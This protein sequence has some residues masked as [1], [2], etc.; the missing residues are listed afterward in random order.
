MR[1][2]LTS[3]A[4]LFFTLNVFSQYSIQGRLLDKE[5]DG[6]IEMATISL[7]SAKDS[8]LISGA[9]SDYAGRYSFSKVAKGDYLISYKYLGY[10][11]VIVQL[12][13]EDKSQ[14]LKNVYLEEEVTNLDEVEVRGMAAQMIIKGDTTEYNAAAFKMQE[15]AVVEDLFK[16]LP[17]FMIESDGSIMVNGE[18]IGR[19]RVDGR[20]FFDGDMEMIT[21]NFTADMVDKIQVFDE[22]SEMAQL[23]GIEDENT[24]RIINI[25][26]KPDRRK[27]VFGNVSGGLGADFDK[28]LRYDE[29]FFKDDFRYDANAM[30]NLF[31]ENFRTTVTT[32][33]NNTNSSR[34]GRGG[35]GR[36]GSGITSTQNIGLNINAEPKTGMQLG[37]STSYNHSS[38]Y[39]NTESFRESWLRDVTNTNNSKS[40]SNSH[41]NNAHLG[42]EMRWQIDSLNTL[43]IQPNASYGLNSSNNRREFDYYTNG[44]STSWGDSKNNNMSDNQN[45]SLNLLFSHRSGRK[46]GRV[47]TFNVNGGISENESLGFNESNKY[48][49]DTAILL[50][51]KSINTSNSYNL[52]LR[53]SLVEPLWNV[54][55]FLEFNA[56][57]NYSNRNSFRNQYD[58][59]EN[60]DYT[61]YNAEYSNEFWNTGLSQNMAMNYNYRDE[62]LNV[63]AGV[64]ASP[65]QTFSYTEYGNGE[66]RDIE[67]KVFNYSPNL[68]VRYNIG[69]SRRHYVRVQYRGRSSEPSVSQMQ[70][71]K[72]NTNLMHETVGNP[73]LLPAFSHSL[74]LNYSKSNP[75]SLASFSTTLSAGMNKDA[76][77]SN[78]IYDAS[79]KEYRQ[80]VNVD[81]AP[82]N[83][84]G[85]VTYNRPIIKNRLHFQTT[86]SAGMRQSIGYSSRNVSSDVIDVDDLILGDRSITNTYNAGENLS[87]TFTHTIIEAGFRGRFNYSRSQN[88][89][90]PDRIQTT[91]NWS[92]NGNV[93]LHLPYDINIDNDLSY[94]ARQGYANFDQNE[95]LWN[96]RIDK[97][98][99]KKKFTLQLRINDILRQRQNINQSIGDNSVS[100]NKSDMLTAY[101]IV[102]LTY[103][104]R[105]FGGRAPGSGRGG[106][107]GFAPGPGGRGGMRGMPGGNFERGSGGG[108]TGSADSGG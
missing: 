24:Q 103:R 75:E 96:A 99:F 9:V 40:S 74:N 101:Y 50:D 60:G 31:K 93:T 90:N 54:Q 80:T 108:N 33:A 26:L 63:V 11:Q 30:V 43:V 6:P 21:K 78:S 27:G 68:S 58:K 22:L 89:L 4:L 82:F 66:V 83:A 106:G 76:L 67:N 13:I 14:I 45:A 18:R 23:T 91:I 49:P 28:G 8:S 10:K 48:T 1:F 88:N 92:A 3:F 15:N 20:R 61:L 97:A 42:F 71:V 19:I 57:V 65:S 5:N 46:R 34:S 36:G 98:V 41:S 84:N 73:G 53:G 7:L 29:N 35:V 2:I 47:L 59:D 70:P 44:D 55:N 39:G 56:S 69:G 79:G 107:G 86:T 12:K 87:L 77:V 62:K 52:G 17:G 37:G 95:L 100:Y 72:N 94:S 38:N 51:Q 102:S 104:I 105:Q 25:T 85:S 64:T 81:K 32:G 16:R